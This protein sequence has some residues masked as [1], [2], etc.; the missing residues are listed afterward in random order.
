MVL[1]GPDVGQLA[2][3]G[4]VAG[5][6]AALDHRSERVRRDAAAALRKVS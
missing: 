3:A 4:D 6:F 1:F 5:L 2:A